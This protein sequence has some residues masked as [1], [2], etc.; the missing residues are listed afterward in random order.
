MGSRGWAFDRCKSQTANTFLTPKIGDLKKTPPSNYGQMVADGA[1]LLSHSFGKCTKIFGWFA[2]KLTDQ[3][4]C[5]HIGAPSPTICGLFLFI[6]PFDCNVCYCWL[7]KQ[8]VLFFLYAT[9]EIC[10]FKSFFVAR[11]G[12]ILLPR[13]WQIFTSIYSWKF[14]WITVLLMLIPLGW[15][16]SSVDSNC[17]KFFTVV[18][19]CM[20]WFEKNWCRCLLVLCSAFNRNEFENDLDVTASQL[21]GL[22]EM[23]AHSPQISVDPNLIFEVSV[24]LYFS[25]T[26][27]LDLSTTL[28][29]SPLC[30]CIINIIWMKFVFKQSATKWP[31][32]AIM[33][34]RLFVRDV[35]CTKT[36]QDR[37]VWYA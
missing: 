28:C 27:P 4:I 10:K 19:P 25:L 33:G 37:F 26:Q 1:Q 34:V 6:T 11:A 12:A 17:L 35:H 23:L 13:F 24:V 32:A 20:I 2:S 21:S 18:A 7:D 22:R 16:Y 5:E 36:V 31:F 29:W 15:W 8:E 30:H 9:G 3:K 14:Q